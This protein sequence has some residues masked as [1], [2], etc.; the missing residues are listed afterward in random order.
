MEKERSKAKDD[1][2]SFKSKIEK[3]KKDIKDGKTLQEE[4]TAEI[5]RQTEVVTQVQSKLDGIK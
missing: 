3:N 2:S 5:S 1:I 4:K